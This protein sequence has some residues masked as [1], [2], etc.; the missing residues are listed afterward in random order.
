MKYGLV[1]EVMKIEERKG[2]RRDVAQQK[3]LLAQMKASRPKKIASPV[4]EP[5]SPVRASPG[6]DLDDVI[7]KPRASSPMKTAESPAPRPAASPAEELRPS[8]SMS[9][10]FS[11]SAGGFMKKDAP[12][13]SNPMMMKMERQS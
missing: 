10:P 12:T 5:E 7:P 3:A 8:S 4:P 1:Q 6:K 13:I 9:K 11:Q 2:V